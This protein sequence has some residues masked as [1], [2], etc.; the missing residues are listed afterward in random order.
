MAPARNGREELPIICNVSYVR[1][2]RFMC[3]SCPAG[4]WAGVRTCVVAGIILSRCNI[5]Q[6]GSHSTSFTMYLVLYFSGL[7]MISRVA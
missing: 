6:V 1:Y 7:P 2:A 3:A 4:P 5:G